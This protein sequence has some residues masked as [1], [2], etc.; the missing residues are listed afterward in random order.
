M[1]FSNPPT[2][3]APFGYSQVVETGPGR[4]IHLAGQ[5]AMNQAGEIVGRGDMGAQA[6]QVFANLAAGLEACGA[7]FRDVVKLTIYVTDITQ[8]PAFRKARDRY[9]T[10]EQPPASTLVVV[11]GLAIDGLLIEIDAT[12]VIEEK[13]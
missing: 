3:P 8:V 7:S 13:R 4:T 5:V 12:A 6:E 10:T 1:R 11:S 2:M 9:V